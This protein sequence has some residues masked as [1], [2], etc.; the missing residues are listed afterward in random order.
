MSSHR[1]R[2]RGRLSPPRGGRG[3]QTAPPARP[4]AGS[5]PHKG[6]GLR[7]AGGGGRPRPGKHMAATTAAPRYVLPAA[8]QCPAGSARPL[9]FCVR[10]VS[11]LVRSPKT[12]RGPSIAA[13]F[14]PGRGATLTHRTDPRNGHGA[15]RNAGYRPPPSGEGGG[16]VASLARAR[17]GVT[18]CLSNPRA[19][20]GP[21]SSR[22]WS[23][24]LNKAA[25]SRRGRESLQEVLEAP[26][27]PAHARWFL[28]L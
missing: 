8:R 15:A 16:T 26:L 2:G 28:C 4:S 5:G 24:R 6:P 18:S 23:V 22:D 17:G 12:A 11:P 10:M 14:P 21:G 13:I 25:A 19:R 1:N 20:H 9:P 27:S 7:A 3:A